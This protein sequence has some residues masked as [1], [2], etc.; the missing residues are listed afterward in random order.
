VPPR[1]LLHVTAICL[2]FA[3]AT[4]WAPPPPKAKTQPGRSA[5]SE[6]LPFAPARKEY[7]LPE[8]KRA[9]PW[10]IRAAAE[11]AAAAEKPK[12]AD[13][14]AAAPAAAEK[15]KSADKPAAAAAAAEKAAV[16]A[17]PQFELLSKVVPGL[18]PGHFSIVQGTV[19][20]FSQEWEAGARNPN[21]YLREVRLNQPALVDQWE[22]TPPEKRIFVIGSGED[23]PKISEWAQSLKSEGNTVFFYKLCR[24]QCS[25]EAVGAMARTS[26]R[27]ML[28]RT[29]SAEL[30]KYVEVEVAQ[31]RFV[32]Q[33]LNKRVILI[34]TEEL[35]ARNFAMHVAT[36]PTPTPS[37]G[38]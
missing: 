29:T 7:F 9:A 1:A 38:K 8:Q 27:I 26:G 34:S 18:S 12:S 22:N 2:L 15:P 37:P 4:V 21:R 31:A 35:F 32:V 5:P 25:S 19:K 20:R 10:E 13:K 17:N 30:S 24:P 33:G 3:A 16:A 14:P 11:K 6:I 23:F 28:Y 36:M